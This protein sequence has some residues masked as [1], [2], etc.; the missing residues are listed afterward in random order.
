MWF[1]ANV[2]ARASHAQ[3]QRAGNGPSSIKILSN[4]SYVFNKIQAAIPVG[5]TPTSVRVCVQAQPLRAIRH[6]RENRAIF[7]ESRLKARF[8]HSVLGTAYS[9]LNNLYATFAIFGKTRRF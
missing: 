9:V 7:H 5:S 4:F 1:V 3:H 2:H 6:L 8:L